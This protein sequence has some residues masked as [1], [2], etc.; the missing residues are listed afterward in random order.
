MQWQIPLSDIDFGIEE[1][2]VVQDVIKSR[3]LTMGEITQT[4]EQEFAEYNNVAHSVAVANGTAAL[5]LACV[6]AGLGPGDEVILPALTFVATANAIRYTGAT[7][8]FADIVNEVDL[9]IS[10]DA[11]EDLINNKTRAIMVMHYGGYACDM[12]RILETANRHN[13]L[14]IEDAAHSPGSELDGKKLGTFGDIGCYSFFSNKNMITGEGGMLVTNDNM[15]AEKTRTLRSHG[16]TAL[17][18]DRYQGHAWS[19]DV[20]DLGFNYRMDEIRAAIGRIQLKKL[21]K[22]NTKRQ[23]LTHHYHDLFIKLAL[24]ITIPFREYRGKSSCHIL[25]IL[26]PEGIDRNQFMEKMKENGIQTS[27]HYP[28]IHQF[29]AY[30]D[31]FDRFQE[32]LPITENIASRE[33]TLPLFP[34]LTKSQVELVVHAAKESLEAI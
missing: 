12:T 10:P 13:L 34:T 4:F 7:P 29:T 21:D 3:W 33:V 1:E 24:D 28:P 26:L 17:T 22:N 27:I 31:R 20:V 30:N 15:L 25:P 6:A 5:H 11:I 18:W 9:N 2:T 8:I 16:M 32:S 19:Y 23:E 14:V